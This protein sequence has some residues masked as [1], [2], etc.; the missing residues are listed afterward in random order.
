MIN[1]K[2]FIL[3]IFLIALLSISVV[4]AEDSADVLVLE[5]SSED[6]VLNEE[7]SDLK[8]SDY[9]STPEELSVDDSED[10]ELDATDAESIENDNIVSKEVDDD[11]VVD[12]ENLALSG[13]T[14]NTLKS[15]YDYYPYNVYVS[16]LTTYYVS[17][18]YIYFGWSGYFSGYFKVY[19][20]SSVV[21]SE[22][23]SGYDDDRKWCIDSLN[24]G[25]YTAKLIDDD[26]GLL[27]YSKISIKKAT[28]KI[29]VKSFIAT[30]GTRF[31]CYAY[32]YDKN[33]GMN[34][35]GGTVKFRIAGKTY[36]AR[37]KN[38]VASFYFKIPKKV[39][40]FTC[41]ATYLATSNVKASSTKF[42]MK[43]K[44]APKYKIVNIPTKMAVSKYITRKVGKYKVQTFKF[45]HSFTTLCVFLY[46]NGKMK[47]RGQYLSKVHYK[48]KGR[49]YWTSWKRGNT[50]CAYHKYII[51]NNV[52]VGN[53]KVKF[54]VA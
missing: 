6:I 52:K 37:L 26:Y 25:T 28:S 46:K 33:D 47:Y 16:P 23:L 17:G 50:D 53:V 10:V 1:K 13:K 19:K 27:D 2:F 5:D 39:R 7:N 22:Y 35:N 15:S 49:W 51:D 18:D 41:K 34:I 14:K 48:Y 40:K 12:D 43:V 9:D 30:A 42:I 36:K 24:A 11:I 4:S 21:F 8:L 54:R 45:K 31:H 32:V 38:G 44:R 20:G 3:A 29:S